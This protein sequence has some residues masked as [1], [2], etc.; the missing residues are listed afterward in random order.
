MNLRWLN[1]FLWGNSVAL[2][3]MWGLGLFFSVQI[4]FM[5]GMSGLLMFAIP[6]ALG[7]MLF[8]WLTQIVARRHPGGDESLAIF[9]DRFSKPF[10][11][12]FY[13]YQIIAL[14]LS[15][16]ALVKYLFVPLFMFTTMGTGAMMALSMI[17]VALVLLA[18]GCLFGEEFGIG[19]IKAGH[20]LL[21]ALLLVCITIV[22]F[23]TELGGLGAGSSGQALLYG[24]DGS[25]FWGYA[26]PLVVGLLVG[27]WLDLQHWQ[28]AIQIHRERTSI[29]LSYIFGGLIFFLLLLFHGTLAMWVIGRAGEAYY[30]IRQG[31]FD[32]LAYGHDLVVQYFKSAFAGN[33]LVPMAYFGFLCICIVTTIDSGYV[34][35]KWFLG[36][37]VEKSENML[38][39]IV[40]KQIVGS[41]IPTFGIV[42]AV[43]L[44]GY[45]AGVELE[46][47]MVFFAS[48][49][50]GYAALAIAR[51]F[52]PNS[53][54][55]LPQIR[56]FAMASLCLVIFAFG[57]L[58]NQN[59]LMYLGSLL[60]L[61][62]VAWL[63]ISTDLL[64]LVTEKAGEVMDAA[65]ELP[66]I[67]AITRP[68]H[69]ETPS[70]Q[71]T[72]PAAETQSGPAHG[73]A[74][75][76]E[77]KWFIHSVIATY[78]DTNS[79][80]NVYFGMYP[81]YVGKARELFFNAVMPDFDLKTTKFYIL[82]RSFEHKFVRETREFDTITVKIKVAEANR[83]FCTLE[84]QIF[85][86]EG[87]LLGKGKQSLLF[88]SS[89][90]YGLLDIPPQVYS[91]F[92]K[93]L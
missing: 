31:R 29:R 89:K 90:D 79:V 76:F 69:H 67:K 20:A 63:V 55:P 47:F 61:A 62:Y 87:Q 8:G 40:P 73:L 51:C 66:A 15:V 52:V 85:G 23:H 43:A 84:H 81:M 28:R 44:I 80:G 74:G 11:L 22:L 5:F 19:K 75:H 9:F 93:F 92:I 34:A 45:F 56:M 91:S 17:M 78:A 6:N 82:T 64:R 41:P 46:Y 26:V 38:L 12:I 77:G 57:Y 7:L 14:S 59:I 4:S 71:V 58:A 30:D 39:S 60:P 3:W 50:V 88:V 35:L 48:F 42:A 16:F 27:P 36:R 32:E 83:K 86:S 49:F 13:I 25:R 1:A 21:G 54:Q 65:A 33:S 37:N 53:Q 72:A 24:Y 10:R 2:A 70:S 68:G 18:I